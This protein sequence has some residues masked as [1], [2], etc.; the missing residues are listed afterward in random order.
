[1]LGFDVLL[2]LGTAGDEL[3]QAILRLLQD[4]ARPQPHL[5]IVG[6]H[7]LIRGHYRALI[8]STSLPAKLS[9]IV[10]LPCATNMKLG[11]G[12]PKFMADQVT[13]T[14]NYMYCISSIV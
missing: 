1:M 4:R 9:T 11:C 8:L 14:Q 7:H 13:A 12:H 2:S 10:P 6:A 5:G 3:P